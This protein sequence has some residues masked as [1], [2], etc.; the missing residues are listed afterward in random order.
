MGKCFCDRE[1][2]LFRLQ[3]RKIMTIKEQ[4]LLLLEDHREE[5]FS[6]EEIAGML[7][8][9]RA[10]VWKAVKTLQKEGYAIE[11][12]NNRGYVLRKAPDVLSAAFIGQE[13]AKSGIS[14]HIQVEK[15]VDSTNNVLK[16]YA[17]EGEK[18]DMVLLAERQSAGRGRRGR[19]F[20][21]PEGTGLYMSLLLHPQAP[22]QEAAM[23]TTLT[24]AAAA[25]AVEAVSGEESEIKWVNDVRMRGRKISGILT[26]GSSSLEE[27]RL[28]Y[29]VVGIGINVYEP[30]EGFPE[31]VREVAGAVFA[32]PA[33]KENMRNRLAAEFLKNFMEY[34]RTFPSRDYLEEYRRRCFVIGKRVRILIPGGRQDQ[35]GCQS[36]NK[37]PGPER[38]YA[39]VLGIDDDCHLKVQY[40]DG[41]VEYLSSGEISIR[42]E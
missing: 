11:A 20:Y 39:L 10:G 5:F 27:G 9:S 13:L 16:Q 21:S 40:D 12:V 8:V 32:S 23:L 17:A 42:P 14:L 31:E 19:S 36:R 26:E 4:V 7:S 30:Q 38:E 41:A 15:Q 2:F 35:T 29:V 1:A 3:E 6:G 28:E 18:R 24:A 34:Y 22:P 37:E 33:P 25:R